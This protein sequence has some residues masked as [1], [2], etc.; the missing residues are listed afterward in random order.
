MMVYD[1]MSLTEIAPVLGFSVEMIT[2]VASS[3]LFRA[4]LEKE[5]LAK[6]KLYR[7]GALSDLSDRVV[8]KFSEIIEKGEIVF[9]RDDGSKHT[10]YIKGRDFIDMGKTVLEMS[11]HG[12]STKQIV[13]H[14]HSS[15]SEAIIQAHKEMEKADEEGADGEVEIIDAEV[16]L[17][18]FNQKT[19]E[20]K[21]KKEMEEA[22]DI[23]GKL[24]SGVDSKDFREW[25][26]A[27][28]E[29]KGEEFV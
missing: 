9:K 12:H 6:A 18:S 26:V 19:I 28:E 21:T 3:P 25:E 10:I 15:L 16:I 23:E 22:E 8:T 24:E 1:E 5:I 20:A 11:G 27:L 17:P 2:L 4:E 13:T 29:E 14:D 7:E